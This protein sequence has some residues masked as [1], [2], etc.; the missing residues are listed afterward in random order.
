MADDWDLKKDEYI[1]ILELSLQGGGIG[2][3]L[4]LV[5]WVGK[6]LPFEPFRTLFGGNDYILKKAQ[7]AVNNAYAAGGEKNLFA[8]IILE[9]EKGV[10]LDETDVKL[11]AG[12]LIVAGSDTTA[13]SLTYLVWCILSRPELSELLCKELAQLSDDYSDRDLEDLPVLN[14]AIEESLRLYGAAPGGIPRQR[15]SGP[16]DLG[17]YLIPAG[18]TVTTQAYSLHRDARLF[19]NP[20]V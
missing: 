12:G 15:P 9:A 8:P 14:A 1:R 10:H 4:P 19:P 2:A 7:I 16:E 17:G 13:V 20:L 3:E 11:E 18:T 6:R 5:R